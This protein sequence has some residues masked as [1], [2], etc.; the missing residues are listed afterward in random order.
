MGANV[1]LQPFFIILDWSWGKGDFPFY[2]GKTTRKWRYC[3]L[4]ASCY[5]SA[6]VSYICTNLI[7]CQVTY[8]IAV[9]CLCFTFMDD[10]NIIK[11]T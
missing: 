5:A 7:G 8:G 3:K 2:M 11:L 9:L 10:L 6:C 1:E 4:L